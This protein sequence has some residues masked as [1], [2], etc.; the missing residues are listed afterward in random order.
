MVLSTRLPEFS[1]MRAQ[2]LMKVHSFIAGDPYSYIKGWNGWELQNDGCV[3]CF[4]FL[5]DA[6]V[7]AVVTW[8]HRSSDVASGLHCS[9]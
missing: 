1:V 2:T 4:V 5:W 9:N 6:T 3:R 7:P 8:M